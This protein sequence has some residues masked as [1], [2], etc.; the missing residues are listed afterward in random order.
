[1]GIDL[2][3]T[4]KA[5]KPIRNNRICHCY[6]IEN[7]KGKIHILCMSNKGIIASWGTCDFCSEKFYFLSTLLLTT[8]KN[9]D[10]ESYKFFQF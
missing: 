5:L 2:F 10:R 9:P 6:N 8:K 4:E 3:V 1:M 7:V